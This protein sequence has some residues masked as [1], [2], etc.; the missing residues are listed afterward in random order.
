M[1]FGFPAL[2]VA[3][4]LGRNELLICAVAAEAERHAQFFDPM[5]YIC[6]VEVESEFNPLAKSPTCDEGLAQINVAYHGRPISIIDNVQRGAGLLGAA[7]ERSHGELLPGLSRY[8][9]GH[10]SR[11]GLRYARR[12]LTLKARLD[13]AVGRNQPWCNSFFLQ[14]SQQGCSFSGPFLPLAVSDKRRRIVWRKSFAR[15]NKD[16]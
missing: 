13:K 7:I 9:T 3:A 8:N 10:I 6:L 15:R 16:V 11:R 12:I 5:A 1:T 14:L 4:L 2:L